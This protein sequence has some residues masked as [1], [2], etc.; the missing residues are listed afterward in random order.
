M[1]FGGAHSIGHGRGETATR[2][3]GQA[4]QIEIQA[5][6]TQRIT[7]HILL[8]LASVPEGDGTMRDHTTVIFMNDNAEH[9]HSK[10]ESWPMYMVGTFEGR[11]HTGGRRIEFPNRYQPGA[12]GLNQVWNTVCHGMCVP[13]DDFAVDPSIPDNRPVPS[14]K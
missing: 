13:T 11:V 5:E 2:P 10:Y 9:H 14:P 4:A 6:L 3:G 8:P 12:R 1:G 7:E